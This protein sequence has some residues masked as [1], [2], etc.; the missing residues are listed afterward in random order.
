MDISERDDVQ[1]GGSMNIQI[2]GVRKCFDTQKAER[3]FRERNIRVQ[4]IDLKEKTLSKGVLTNVKAAVGLDALID[5]TSRDYQRLNLNYITS[6][7]LREELLLS[8]PGLYVTP[9]VRNG[10][11]AT[12]GYRPEIWKDWT[13]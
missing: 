3:Y 2:Y 5:K 11:Q 8:N 9:I 10:R 13:S 7:V 12:V 6:P 4:F 1:D